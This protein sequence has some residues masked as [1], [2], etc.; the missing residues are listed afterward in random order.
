MKSTALIL[1]LLSL[2]SSAF[3]MGSKRL[4][5]HAKL[6]LE[7]GEYILHYENER[8]HTGGLFVEQINK[9]PFIELNNSN[10]LF[11]NDFKD[12]KELSFA[13]ALA[14]AVGCEESLRFQPIHQYLSFMLEV[15]SILVLNTEVKSKESTEAILSEIKQPLSDEEKIEIIKFMGFS[16]SPLSNVLVKKLISIF[17]PFRNNGVIAYNLT[18]PTEEDA[19]WRLAIGRDFTLSAKTNFEIIS[20]LISPKSGKESY[21]LGGLIGGGSTGVGK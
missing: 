5:T 16:G 7:D 18:G 13:Q 14:C 8:I 3:S 21:G 12:P 4:D 11:Q 19:D 15:E 2:C 6:S 20:E 1:L 10:P 9:I 17:N